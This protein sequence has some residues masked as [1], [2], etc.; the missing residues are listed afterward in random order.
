VFKRRVGDIRGG[1]AAW[2]VVVKTCEGAVM[3][4]HGG[5]DRTAAAPSSW[6]GT[7]SG[8]QA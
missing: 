3:L 5:L 4:M 7:M 8:R 2:L 6:E 1:A